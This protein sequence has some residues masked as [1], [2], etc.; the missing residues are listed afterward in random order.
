LGEVAGSQGQ[1]DEA[2][3]V[4]ERSRG[5]ARA[6]GHVPLLIAA[7]TV[8]GEVARTQGDDVTAEP[9]YREAL[10]LARERNDAW[11]CSVLL[12]NLGHINMHRGDFS[13]AQQCFQE[14]LAIEHQIDSL[15]NI[16]HSLT[17]FAGTLGWLGKPALAARLFGAA[18]QILA[19]L[20]TPLD[21]ADQ[22]EYERN[23]AHARSQLDAAAFSAAWAAGRSLAPAQ[24]V[25]EALA[26]PAPDALTAVRAGATVPATAAG[27]L[28][29]RERDVLA[30]VAQGRSNKEIAVALTISERTVNTHLVHIFGKLDVSSRAAATAAALRL[31]L[32][33]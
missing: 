23:L 25:A 17:G 22:A 21:F 14:S 33:E 31:G 8:L 11:R 3:Q 24:A 32:I 18:E 13:G 26:I 20:G 29:A 6:A 12:Q 9:L 2:R 1:Y 10:D 15:W 19:T 28:T 5:L 30:L 4:L 16:A 7:L 27:G